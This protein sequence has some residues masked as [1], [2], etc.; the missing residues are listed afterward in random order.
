MDKSL[1]AC[2]ECGRVGQQARG[3]CSTCY[4]RWWKANN[5]EKVKAAL[6]RSYENNRVTCPDCHG[7]MHKRA[8]LCR[9]CHFVQLVTNAAENAG[10]RLAARVISKRKY[11]ASHTLQ[12][13]NYTAARRARLLGAKATL[14]GDEWKA[15]VRRYDHQCAY[16][17]QEFG[18]LE[19]DHVVPLS[20]GGTHTIEN[21]VPACFSCNR[22]KGS[23]ANVTPKHPLWGAIVAEGRGREL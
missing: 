11:E 14:T 4:A 3:L 23:R 8:T 6:L 22:S 19:Q 10:E 16:C 7:P 17:L 12:R 5:P 2:E 9:E 13:K 15:L 20:K 21:V 18:H 1:R